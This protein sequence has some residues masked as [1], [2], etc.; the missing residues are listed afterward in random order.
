MVINNKYA[1]MK[2]KNETNLI[3]CMA[4]CCGKTA[5]AGTKTSRESV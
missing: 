5:F 1:N 4:C 2:T 3:M